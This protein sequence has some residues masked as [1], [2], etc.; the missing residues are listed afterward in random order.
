[1][2]SVYFDV[3]SR[4]IAD[5]VELAPNYYLV[6]RINVPKGSRGRGLGS[7]VLREMLGDADLEGATLEIHPMPSGGL[8][9]KQL[10]SW[11]ERYGFR[12]GQSFVSEE[13]VKV[14]VRVPGGVE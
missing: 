3:E 10:I 12:M 4:T 11:Y 9:R 14:L 8:T 5:L 13:P 1:M 2:K 7:K 6:I